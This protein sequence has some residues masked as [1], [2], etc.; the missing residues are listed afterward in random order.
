MRALVVEDDPVVASELVRGMTAAGFVVD[1]AGDGQQAWF[2]GDVED[3]DVAIVDL[4]LPRK[5]GL[6]HEVEIILAETVGQIGRRELLDLDRR[7]LINLQI[8]VEAVVQIDLSFLVDGGGPDEFLGT[9]EELPNA[10]RIVIGDTESEKSAVKIGGGG[11]A[12]RRS[13]LAVIDDR[14]PAGRKRGP[15]L[16]PVADKNT[17]LVELGTGTEEKAVHKCGLEIAGLHEPVMQFGLHNR[18]KGRSGLAHRAVEDDDEPA[19]D[20][21]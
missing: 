2:N 18:E 12:P 8:G 14:S 19:W 21:P 20:P 3:Y 17:D 11:L 5:M 9:L 16:G 7:R 15:R 1:L 10:L 13:H 6:L 4:G